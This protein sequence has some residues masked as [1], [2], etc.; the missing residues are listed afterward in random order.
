MMNIRL[1]FA[2]AL[3]A[4][5]LPIVVIALQPSARGI[6]IRTLSTRPDR[7]SGGDVLMEIVVPADG[8]P[9]VALN[10]REISSSF[11]AAGARRF[12]G[13]LSGLTNGRNTVKVAGRPWKVADA[14][15]AITSYPSTGPIVSGPH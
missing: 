8:A 1:R 9:A 5:A 13:L 4:A 6:E 7:V 12:A 2:L 14:S 15:L 3:A 10:G 11:H